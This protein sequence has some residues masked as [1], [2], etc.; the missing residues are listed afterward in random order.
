VSG[1][2]R[3]EKKVDAR[4]RG[5]VGDGGAR[6]LKVVTSGGAANSAID[7]GGEASVRAWDEEG[8]RGP[9][10]FG[11]GVKVGGRGGAE[12]HRAES[13]LIQLH[14]FGVADE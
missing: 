10:L 13:G 5:E 8:G 3:V 2:D 6:R 9:L 12:M 11:D 1:D 14:Q 4:K 7:A